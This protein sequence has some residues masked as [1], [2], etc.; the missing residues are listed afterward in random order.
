MEMWAFEAL[1]ILSGLLPHHIVAVAAHSVL[2]NVNL[3]VYTTFDGLSVA[4]NIRVGNCLGA[5][6]AKTAKLACT[7]VL[8]MTVILA[9]TFTAVLYG[10]NRQIPR[11]FLDEGDSVDLAA[12]VLAI[13]SPL[14]IV[15]GLNAVTQGVLRGAGKQKAAAITN[16]LAYYLFGIPLGV[17]LAFQCDLGVEGLWL[18]MGFGSAVNF[19]AMALLMLCRWSWE[20]L[21]LAAKDLTDL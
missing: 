1:T 6:H 20:G 16:G 2:V 7:V 3:L 17:F 5:G 13:W 21:A 19:G 8:T 18:G 9:L 12:K 15:D 11:A 4:A 14:T 10:F